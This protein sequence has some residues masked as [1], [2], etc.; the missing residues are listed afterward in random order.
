ML[1]PSE[2]VDAHEEAE[3][4]C[5]HNHGGFGWCC[6]YLI[7]KKKTSFRS[8]CENIYTSKYIHVAVYVQYSMYNG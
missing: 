2:L 1:R 8:K 7:R 4:R 3:V 6:V 5:V